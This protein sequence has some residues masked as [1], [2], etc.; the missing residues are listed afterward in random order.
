MKLVCFDTHVLVWGIRGEATPGQE[1]MI[2][3]TRAFLQQLDQTG[4]RVIIPTIV[5]GEFLL[6]HPVEEHYKVTALFQQHFMVVPYDLRAAKLFADLWRQEQQRLS[7]MR[8]QFG[9][10]RVAL[11]A[12]LMIAA[13]AMAAGAA[14]IYSEDQRMRNFVSRA[15]DVLPI[16]NSPL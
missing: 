12:D 4:T 5:I 7:E 16:P 3:R 8:S 6:A 2:E 11:I 10:T 1:Y 9:S 14:C 15:I 13:T